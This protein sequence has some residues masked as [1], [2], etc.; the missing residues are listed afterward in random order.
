VSDPKNT[1]D[2]IQYTLMSTK[3]VPQ[4]CVASHSCKLFVGSA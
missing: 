2:D 4:E 3:R 1:L